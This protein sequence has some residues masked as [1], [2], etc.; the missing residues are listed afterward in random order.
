MITGSIVL[1]EIRIESFVFAPQHLHQDEQFALD[2]HICLHHFF[3]FCPQ[4]FMKRFKGLHPQTNYTQGR[5]MH[6]PS[7]MGIAFL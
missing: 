2:S 4:P 6:C 1:P 3:S 7:D 5:H